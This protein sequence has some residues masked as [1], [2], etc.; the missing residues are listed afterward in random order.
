MN[1]MD[2]WNTRQHRRSGL[3]DRVLASRVGAAEAERRTLE[4][5]TKACLGE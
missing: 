4:F 1:A 2:E 3:T 5:L